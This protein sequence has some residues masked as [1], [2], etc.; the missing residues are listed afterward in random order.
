MHQDQGGALALGQLGECALDV[1]LAVERT[2]ESG[3]LRHLAGVR[4]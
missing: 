2:V 3:R 4:Q 1:A